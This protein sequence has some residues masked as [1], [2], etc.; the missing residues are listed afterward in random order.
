MENYI[1]VLK[2]TQLF[3]GLDGDDIKE[4]LRCLQA[5][6]VS[7][8]KDEYVY[9]QG[10]HVDNI[11]LLISG[12]LHIQKED[13]WGNLSII[14]RIGIGEM[15]GE[16]YVAYSGGLLNDVVAIED[17]VVLFFDVKKIFSA[18]VSACKFHVMVVQNMFFAIA[19]RNRRL[20]QKLGHMSNRTTRQKLMSYLSEQAAEH[21]SDSFSIPFNRQQLAD[22]LAVDRSAMSGELCKMR[23]DGLIKF[24]KN[25]FTLL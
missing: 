8:K 9:R 3:A 5:R 4:M 21:R 20:V 14:N 25:N 11:S 13:Y 7:F 18:C 22:F 17:S 2:R 19:E 23:N 6:L 12:S 15:F 16:A 1:N 24:S 10:E